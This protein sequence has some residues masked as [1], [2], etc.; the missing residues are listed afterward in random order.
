M[1]K[2]LG[3]LRLNMILLNVNDMAKAKEFYTKKLGLKRTHSDPDYV[4]VKTSNGI[5]IGLHAAHAKTKLK[6]VGSEYYLQVNDT[7]AWYERL[8]KKGVRFSQRPKN[9][10][11]GSR[12]AFF[13]DPDGY[14]FGISGPLKK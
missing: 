12:V 1:P 13:R 10:P 14:L 9:M 3:K 8:K 4:G 6:P 2:K 7:D 11:W 5:H